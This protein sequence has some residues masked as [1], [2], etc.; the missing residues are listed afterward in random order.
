MKYEIDTK[1]KYE[2]FNKSQLPIFKTNNE[3]TL[4]TSAQYVEHELTIRRSQG[5]SRYARCDTAEEFV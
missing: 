2:I 4:L 1:T 5:R 3:I